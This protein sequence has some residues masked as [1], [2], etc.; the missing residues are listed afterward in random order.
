V[1]TKLTFNLIGFILEGI[2][3]AIIF[4]SHRFHRLS[5][6]SCQYKQDKLFE[7]VQLQQG[8]SNLEKLCPIMP[9]CR[10]NKLI[11]YFA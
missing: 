10:K 3:I 7:K 2:V 4:F 1:A 6:I 8:I 11:D 9:E 5:L